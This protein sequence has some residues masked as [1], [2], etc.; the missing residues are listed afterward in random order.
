M[1]FPVSIFL[2]LLGGTCTFALRWDPHAVDFDAVGVIL[3]LSGVLGLILHR[4]VLQ[5]RREAARISGH[6]PVRRYDHPGAMPT[7]PRDPRADD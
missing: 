1:L 4:Y 5:R 3:M 7:D 2:I 6:A